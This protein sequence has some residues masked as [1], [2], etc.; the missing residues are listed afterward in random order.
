[1]LR[2][3]TWMDRLF[4]NSL[5]VVDDANNVKKCMGLKKMKEMY[6]EAK[7]KLDKIEEILKEH[8]DKYK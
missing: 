6:E 3:A 4:S 8:K 5:L 2:K 7:N 1:M